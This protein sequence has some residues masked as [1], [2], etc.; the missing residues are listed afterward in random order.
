M[1]IVITLIFILIANAS[2][3]Y[4]R[5]VPTFDALTGREVNPETC[6][7]FTLTD[8]TVVELYAILWSDSVTTYSYR[9]DFLGGGQ[10]YG[11]TYCYPDIG[12]VIYHDFGTYGEFSKLIITK[13]LTGLFYNSCDERVRFRKSL[14]HTCRTGGGGGTGTGN[15]NCP[16]PGDRTVVFIDGIE[17]PD[18]CAS[19]V[20]IDVLG[21][22]FSLTNNAGGVLF[23]LNSNDNREQVAWTSTNSDD[24]WLVLDRNSNGLIDNGTELFGDYTPQPVPPQNEE[25]NGFLALAEFDKAA[26]GGNSD[27]VI[28]SSDTIFSNLRLWQDTNHNGVSELSE[29]KTLNESGLVKLELN[30]RESKR[31]DEHGNRFKY[32]AKVWDVRGSRIG[33]WAWDV[34]LNSQPPQN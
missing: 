1:K 3:L 12:N 22:G 28:D 17:Q 16:P 32:R 18:E 33:R 7:A 9:G 19:P 8:I 23:D 30:Y 6:P 26:N 5:C 24:A 27:G 13:Q 34:F 31:T 4:G 15:N 21:N 14:R 2:N 11:G 25:R 20:V 29:L 10:C